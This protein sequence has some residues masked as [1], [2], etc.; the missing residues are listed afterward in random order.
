MDVVSDNNITPSC[1]IC[2]SNFTSLTENFCTTSCNH[3]FH[4][5]C[6]AKHI[7]SEKNECPL[8]RHVLFEKTTQT[9]S[10]SETETFYDELPTDTNTNT[11][12]FDTIVD[13]FILNRITNHLVRSEISYKQLVTS[14]CFLEHDEFS[15]NDTLINNSDYIFG[16]I[17]QVLNTIQPPH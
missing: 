7:E 2:L 1:S 5:S 8:C 17:R 4:L 15:G 6:I 12:N 9:E 13:E 11:N 16:K 10:S 14:L 3:C